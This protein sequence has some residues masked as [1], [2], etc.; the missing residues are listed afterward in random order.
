M[1]Y[2]RLSQV[3]LRIAP[4]VRFMLRLSGIESIEL[5]MFQQI[6]RT[7]DFH[8]QHRLPACQQIVEG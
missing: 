5:V 8:S 7:S 2:I 4:H 6:S 1:D 3:F